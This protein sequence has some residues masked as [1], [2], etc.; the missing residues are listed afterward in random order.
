MHD[1]PAALVD[2]FPT[3]TALRHRAPIGLDDLHI[4]A[5]FLQRVVC[6]IA[7]RADRDEVG[8]TDDHHFLAVVARRL[9]RAACLVQI[10][11]HGRRTDLAAIRCAARQHRL[12][13]VVCGA[14]AP[15]DRGH[16]VVLIDRHQHRAADRDVVERRMQMVEAQDAVEPGGIGAA[17]RDVGI[18]PQQRHKVGLDLL[19]P[20][21]L[22]CLQ[23]GG[24]G[25]RVGNHAP[26]QAVEVRDLAAGGPFGGFCARHIVRVLLVDDRRARNE[27]PL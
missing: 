27:L 17:D 19:V 24:G 11:W 8:R 4:H 15:G 12:T 1:R 6:D 20:I 25:R 2:W 22:T 13:T 18:A 21:D 3:G 23:R 7:H 10:A 16:V 5:E 14:V 26:F 9:K